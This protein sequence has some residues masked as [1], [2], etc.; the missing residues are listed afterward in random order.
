LSLA[1]FRA[2]I[3]QTRLV[4]KKLLLLLGLLIFCAC[5]IGIARNHRNNPQNQVYQGKTLAAWCWQIY[6]PDPNA[7]E[8]AAA[9]FKAMGKE[10]V[11]GLI[12]LLR[13]KDSPFNNFIWSMAPK[14]PRWLSHFLLKR[15]PPLRAGAVHGAA[16]RCLGIIGSDAAPAV[17]D[18][19]LA[20]HDPE[21]GL[22]WDAAT[23]LAR[24]GKASVPALVEAM[25]ASDPNL[26]HAAVFGLTE[27]GSESPQAVRALVDALGDSSEPVRAS[28][29][30]G[31][32]NIGKPIVPTLTEAMEKGSEVARQAAGTALIS[33]CPLPRIVVPPFTKMLQDDS[34]RLR[35]SAA[36]ALGNACAGT[37]RAIP[38]LT[39]AADDTDEQVR[40]AA[41][42]ALDKIGSSETTPAIQKSD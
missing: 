32:G 26:R 6:S 21:I 3:L 36:R 14:L 7:H 27:I 24:I 1:G 23:A 25:H 39:R 34:P 13:T 30:R 19:A 31:L 35:E 5:L 28:A 41:K 10:A 9:A 29:I 4:V 20:L 2:S 22:R 40:A 11:P 18:L 16:A 17:P 38:E 37:K 15:T 33:A 42:E 12:S 8:Q